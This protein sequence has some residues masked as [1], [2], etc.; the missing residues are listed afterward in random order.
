MHAERTKDREVQE[1]CRRKVC[2]SECKCRHWPFICGYCKTGILDECK[3]C[4]S[5][6][7]HH[8]KRIETVWVC[9]HPD[10]GQITR[11]PS[12]NM[13][14]VHFLRVI[15]GLSVKDIATTL[16]NGKPSYN[17]IS[18][19]TVRWLRNSMVR[20]C[21]HCYKR[22]LPTDDELRVFVDIAMGVTQAETAFKYGTTVYGVKKICRKCLDVYS[23]NHKDIRSADALM[24]RQIRNAV[25][26]GSAGKLDA[27]MHPRK[28]R[29]PQ[30]GYNWQRGDHDSGISEDDFR[31]SGPPTKS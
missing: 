22:L 28:A 29:H 5:N 1:A 2:C 10:C 24:R 18:E 16:N 3:K 21:E 19:G 14:R 13:L 7:K 26:I 11:A 25:Q 15:Q 12:Y 4:H 17:Q 20:L 30:G 31:R 9:P 27:V 23:M 6:K 8:G